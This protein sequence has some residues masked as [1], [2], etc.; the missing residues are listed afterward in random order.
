[1]FYPFVRLLLIVIF[2]ILFRFKIIGTEN[3]PLEGPLIIAANHRSYLDPILLA[4]SVKNREINFMAKGSLF[5]YPVFGTTIRMLN[6]FPVTKGVA[7][8]AALVKSLRILE[9]GDVLVIF[10]EGTRYLEGGLGP[11][12]PGATAI[13]LKTGA[14]ILPVGILG[15]EKVMPNGAGIPRLPKLKVRI[16]RPIPVE[17]SSG[18]ERKAMEEKLTVGMMAEIG[19]LIAD[20]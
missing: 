5:R 11:A 13:A 17:K 4:I 2:K 8:K 3:V 16:G 12:Y 1:V 15:T 20:G 18:A 10:P 6:A 9:R 14:T 7:D 19:K